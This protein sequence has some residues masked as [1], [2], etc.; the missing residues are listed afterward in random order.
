[1]KKRFIA[2]ISSL[3]LSI[4]FLQPAYA[5]KAGI[6]FKKYNWRNE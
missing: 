2:V 6:D 4:S 1:M 5:E 3:L